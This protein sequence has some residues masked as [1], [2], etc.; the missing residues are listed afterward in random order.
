[1]QVASQAVEHRLPRRSHNSQRF[2]LADLLAPPDTKL[3]GLSLPP[4][5]AFA[6]ASLARSHAPAASV[7][8]EGGRARGARRP[9]LLLLCYPVRLQPLLVLSLALWT[10]VVRPGPGYECR[11]R[12]H[13]E[14]GKISAHASGLAIDVEGFELSN[15]RML[16]FAPKGDEHMRATVDAIRVAACGW[17]TTVFGPGSDEA[18]TDHLH[19][20]I[21]QHGSSDRFRICQ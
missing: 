3:T 15:G 1:M 10:L 6:R 11:N 4:A 20:D 14:D 16:G 5:T 13:A 18:H 12:N 7:R 8:S 19:V 21:L 9:S 17:F 2:P